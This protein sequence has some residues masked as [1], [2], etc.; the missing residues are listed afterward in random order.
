MKDH[1]RGQDSGAGAKG[2]ESE[3]RGESRYRTLFGMSGE[4]VFILERSGR[5][6]DLNPSA[7]TACG[8]NRRDLRFRKAWDVLSKASVDLATRMSEDEPFDGTAELQSAGESPIPVEF[9]A[10][11]DS[12]DTY[13][14]VA[15]VIES[16][17]DAIESLHTRLMQQALV[18]S[19]G[20]F[21][22]RAS[23]VEDVFV[24]AVDALMEGLGVDMAK[25]LRLT[26][27]RDAVGL[28]HGKGWIEAL[29]GDGLVPIGMDSQAGYTLATSRPVIVDD[30]LSEERFDGPALLRNHG[31]VSGVSCIIGSFENPWGVLG[32]H[33]Q[34]RRKFS[35][36]DAHF[37]AGVANVIAQAVASDA[38]DLRASEHELR[39]ELALQAADLVMW[40]YEPQSGAMLVEGDFASALGLPKGHLGSTF[41][42]FLQSIHGDDRATVVAAMDAHLAGDEPLFIAKFR[43]PNGN[44]PIWVQSRG[45]VVTRMGDGTPFRLLGVHEDVSS[46][47]RSSQRERNLQRQLQH[48]HK[49]EAVGR[50][51]GGIAH[52]FNNILTAITGYVELALNEVHP[53]SQLAGDLS[54]IQ[55]ASDRARVLTRQLLTFS[56][57]EVTQPRPV[58]IDQ[59]IESLGRILEKILGEE[60]ELSLDLKSNAA[61]SVIDPSQFEQVVLNLTSNAKDAM[62][63]GGTFEISS[64]VV[65]PAGQSY[66]SIELRFSDDGA[67]IPETNIPKLFE[68]FFT[69]KVGG[70]GTG[71][72][73]SLVFGVIESVG[74]SVEVES[75]PGEGTTFVICLPATSEELSAPGSEPIAEFAGRARI[76]LI[77]DD[78]RLRG[79]GERILRDAGYDVVAASSAH[80]AM[81]IAESSLPFH[82]VVTDVVM[83]ETSGPEIVESLRKSQPDLRV[84]FVS[85]YNEE[86]TVRK[87]VRLDEVNY[88]AKPFTPRGMLRMV[89][90]ALEEDQD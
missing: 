85:G 10:R 49:M 82:L 20:M 48:A 87:G 71:L 46:Q 86:T 34:T 19:L 63:E 5:I 77:E 28:V 52:D 35:E 53:G 61:F 33:S 70:N 9:S 54:E 56:R 55:S 89:K 57:K 66:A 12:N 47:V 27:E 17:R 29:V 15:Q 6:L 64:K 26:P 43:V 58:E 51:A 88:L 45:R 39:L 78:D 41:E 25:V 69:T 74:G 42:Q 50:L 13:V 76:L 36:H 3:V 84:L 23:Q 65:V 59:T 7:S 1:D 32:A 72:G 4:L 22:L 68:P 2:D 90:R 80:Q 30:L 67:G 40:Q 83:P 24:R 16:D 73:L 11:L 62:P 79:L 38:A 14:V 21:A 37:L 18:A 8:L 60:I 31:V 75:T 81:S 44:E